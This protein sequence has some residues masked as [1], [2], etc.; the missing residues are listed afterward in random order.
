[1]RHEATT[2]HLRRSNPLLLIAT[3]VAVGF[4]ALLSVVVLRP[5]EDSFPTLRNLPASDFTLQLYSGGRIAGADYIWRV[6][7]ARRSSSI[8]GGPAVH[9]AYRKR[10]Y[11]S[12]SGALGGTRMS[13]SS[14]WM[15][16]TILHRQ[17]PWIS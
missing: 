12:D 5:A 15:N 10:Q 2:N 17:P 6:C 8:S 9:P 1:M 4:V 7:M 16:S 13:S 14:E 3:V 11:W